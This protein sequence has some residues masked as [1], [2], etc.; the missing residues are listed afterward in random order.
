MGMRLNLG[1]LAADAGE[2]EVARALLEAN[3]AM[4]DAQRLFRCV[5]WTTL[6]LAELALADGDE[7]ARPSWS[8]P[9]LAR[10][11]PLGD[12][13]G[14]ARSLELGEAAAKRPLSPAREG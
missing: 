7:A 10:L 2:R 14:L 13:W 8:T 6:A 12:R 3:R 4:A 11:R 5:G 1:H 9:R